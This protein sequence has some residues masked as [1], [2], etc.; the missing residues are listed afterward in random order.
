M[1]RT[2][3]IVLISLICIT[4]TFYFFEKQESSQLTVDIAKLR[5]DLTE[6]T[7]ASYRFEEKFDRA[8]KE[9]EEAKE[10]VVKMKVNTARI[11]QEAKALVSSLRA[12]LEKSNSAV[13]K[14]FLSIKDKN[15]TDSLIKKGIKIVHDQGSRQN[16]TELRMGDENTVVGYLLINDT[17]IIFST[18]IPGLSEQD[19]VDFNKDL[20]IGKIM[21]DKEVGSFLI[22]SIS[23]WEKR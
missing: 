1:N 8:E 14:T 15:V 5:H 22:I 6:R 20:Y 7:L 21:F 3:V 4:S 18:P 16:L 23:R 12:E 2:L 11:E 10:L 17:S 19:C 9:K 13:E